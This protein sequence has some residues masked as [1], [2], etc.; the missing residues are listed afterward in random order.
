MYAT[1]HNPF[2]YFHSIIDSPIC[3][4]NVVDL[5]HLAGDLA[6]SRRRLR[7]SCSSRRTSAT[8]ATTTP[9]IDGATGRPG[10]RPTNF[11]SAAW[12]PK[13]MASPAFKADG[14]LDRHLRRG[15]GERRSRRVLRGRQPPGGGRIGARCSWARAS[16][17]G[18]PTAR[19]TTTTGFLC[20]L[21]NLFGLAAPRKG[22]DPGDAVLRFRRLRLVVAHQQADVRV[23]AVGAQVLRQQDGTAREAPI[24]R[25]PV[26]RVRALPCRRATP[27]FANQSCVT[28]G[29]PVIRF[30][31]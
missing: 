17:R 15:A 12:V 18:R 19:R 14:L 20:S 26:A 27:D 30:H 25:S 11:L 24:A 2:V 6:S 31:W 5:D 9:C 7:T 16:R 13:I 28:A 23:E 4:T 8:T 29:P 10:V 21:E 3:K 1:Q 22:R